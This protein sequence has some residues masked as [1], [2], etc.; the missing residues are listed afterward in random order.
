[1]LFGWVAEARGS[2][3]LPRLCWLRPRVAPAV[4]LLR[5]STQL[6]TRSQALEF[7]G[8]GTEDRGIFLFPEESWES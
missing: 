8:M 6:S 1:M 2:L 5:L 3:L 7:L 4:W